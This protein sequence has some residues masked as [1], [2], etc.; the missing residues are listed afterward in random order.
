MA[1]FWSN[2]L[3]KSEDKYDALRERLSSHEQS[4]EE[5]LHSSHPH[6]KELFTKH[7]INLR[8][9][10]R[11]TPKIIAAAAVLGAF[12]AIPHLIGHPSITT[13]GAKPVDKGGVTQPVPGGALPAVPATS[14]EGPAVGQPGPGGSGAPPTQPPSP[15]SGEPK[16]PGKEGSRGHM[17]GRSY[18]TPPKAHGLH[19][20]G[21]HKGEDKG[22]GE[23]K[24]H[25][26][27]HPEELEVR[28]PERGG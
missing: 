19:N 11:H 15:P 12:L 16:E 13:P 17:F 26:G 1:A 20:I 23:G 2:L 18:L 28:H 22:K 21:L 14:Q 25:E 5:N 7:D 9:I 10:R 3:G 27:A 24:G 4:S 6:L 8:Q